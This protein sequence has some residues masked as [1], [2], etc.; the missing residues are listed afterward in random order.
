MTAVSMERVTHPTTA[1]LIEHVEAYLAPRGMTLETFQ[2]LGRRDELNDDELR[3]LWLAV[4]TA[5][6]AL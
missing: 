1:E 3:D 5:L 4:G 6:P 2:D